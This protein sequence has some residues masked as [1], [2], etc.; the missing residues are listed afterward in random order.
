[1]L[2][3]RYCN[4]LHLYYDTYMINEVFEILEKREQ[5]YCVVATAAQNA[6]PEAALVGYAVTKDQKILI[7]TSMRSR[8]YRNIEQNNKVSLV[9]GENFSES[10]IQVD[11]VTRIIEDLEEVKISDEIFYGAHPE[12]KQFK[13]ENTMFISI[14]PVWVRLMQFTTTPPRI[15]EEVLL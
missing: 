1:M 9:I 6:K 12:A 13:D 5:K 3:D 4:F 10:N 8:K 2:L 14:T 7:A 15:E 11:G